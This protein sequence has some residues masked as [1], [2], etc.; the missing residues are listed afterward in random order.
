MLI[1]VSTLISPKFWLFPRFYLPVSCAPLTLWPSPSA[2]DTPS[3]CHYGTQFVHI[4]TVCIQ[5]FLYERGKHSD[6]YLYQKYS[7][8][9]EDQTVFLPLLCAEHASSC[10]GYFHC[11]R[12]THVL[13][14]VKFHWLLHD[15]SMCHGVWSSGFHCAYSNGCV[16]S[17]NVA[18]KYRFSQALHEPYLTW[19]WRESNLQFLNTGIAKSLY[20]I[21]WYTDTIRVDGKFWKLSKIV[22]Q[23]ANMQVIS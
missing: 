5:N 22:T 7:I 6:T 4:C 19:A 23:I 1:S 21:A 15:L 17:G 11:W 3:P 8:C 10:G 20:M 18:V 13:S 9:F 14:V 16:N 12:R 2:S